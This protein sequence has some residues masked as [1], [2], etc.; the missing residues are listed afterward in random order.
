M[1]Y[2][3]LEFVPTPSEKH[4]GVVTLSA[5]LIDKTRII[6]RYKLHPNKDAT[7][8]FIGVT[9]YKMPDRSTGDEYDDCFEL[10][11]KYAEKEIKKLINANVRGL[12]GSSPSVF[13]KPAYSPQTSQPNLPYP[14]QPPAD[15]SYCSS[16]MPEYPQNQPEIPF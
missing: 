2:D 11:S 3:F 4:I 12:P 6:L 5:L 9:G 13:E 16:A 15:F 8:Y 14:T 7:G 1:I 10:D